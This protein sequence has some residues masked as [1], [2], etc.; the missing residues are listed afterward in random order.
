MIFPIHE[1]FGRS[2]CSLHSKEFFIPLIVIPSFEYRSALSLSIISIWST[3][4]PMSRPRSHD[5]L[6]SI[7]SGYYVSSCQDPYSHKNE[8]V[9]EE[10]VVLKSAAS[11]SSIIDIVLSRPH[12]S[13]FA[14]SVVYC[15]RSSALVSHKS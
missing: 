9:S 8:H 15:S 13:C 11:K 5:D 1:A 6:Q 7:F 2:E 4:S 14:Y 3:V 10:I 12:V